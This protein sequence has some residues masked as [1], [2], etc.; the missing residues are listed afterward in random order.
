M[1]EEVK[2]LKRGR[3]QGREAGVKERI[4]E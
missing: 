2:K 1:E 3:R 4:K